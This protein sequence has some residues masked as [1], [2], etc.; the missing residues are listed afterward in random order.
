V[1]DEHLVSEIG[2]LYAQRAITLVEY[3]AGIRYGTVILD[4]L[5]TIDAPSPYSNARSEEFPDDVCLR[6]KLAMAS[7]RQ[8][9][10]DLNDPDCMR[11]VDR[12]TV[13][14]EPL[15]GDDLRLL[16]KG[17]QALSGN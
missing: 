4:Y 5:K 3:E 1:T 14:G 2:G 8:I 16:R 7:A 9:L 13:Y 10:K 15:Y 6:R 17:L 11:V 12:V